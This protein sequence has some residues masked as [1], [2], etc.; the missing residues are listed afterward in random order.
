MK[1]MSPKE[2]KKENFTEVSPNIAVWGSEQG[3]IG[4]IL[5]PWD[6]GVA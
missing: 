2:W 1:Q 5:F 3:A 6:F 4:I